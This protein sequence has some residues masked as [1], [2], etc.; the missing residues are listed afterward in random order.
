M[1]TE[2][3]KLITHGEKSMEFLRGGLGVN[4]STF[5]SRFSFEGNA[6]KNNVS[7]QESNMIPSMK[8]ESVN[9]A[10]K[11]GSAYNKSKEVK[12]SLKNANTQKSFQ[13]DSGFQKT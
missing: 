5:D 6:Y 9:F 12:S 11:P 8:M 4:S 13:L 2:D 3:F 1:H 7:N 10:N